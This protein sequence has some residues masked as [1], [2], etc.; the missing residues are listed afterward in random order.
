MCG[1]FYLPEKDIDDFAGLVNK[2]EKELLKKAG[3]I[4]PGDY[5][6]VITPIKSIS[7]D[8]K[9]HEY[10]HHAIKWGFP[11]SKGSPIFNARCE[12]INEKPLFKLP[13]ATKRCLIPVRGF[14]EWKDSENSK[15]RIKHF[16]SLNN[17]EDFMYLA[18][19]YWFF[20]DTEGKLIPYYTIITT[21]ANEDIITIHNRMPVI[22]E[23]KNKSNWLYSC[24]NDLIQELMRPIAKG[25]LNIS[26]SD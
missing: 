21:A 22:I 25:V 9:V 23:E 2:V 5:A 3:E 12:T 17:N 13:F 4:A 20:K 15:K 18:G 16:I 6:P 26:I 10:D 24:N 7:H 8:Q 14:F 19:I 1:R 11:A